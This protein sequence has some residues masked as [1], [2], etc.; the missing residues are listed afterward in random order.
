MTRNNNIDKYKTDTRRSILERM[1][2]LFKQRE[3]VILL[4]KAEKQSSEMQKRWLEVEERDE[5]MDEL[6][7]IGDGTNLTYETELMLKYL[8]KREVKS[9]KDVAII[10]DFKRTLDSCIKSEF[11]DQSENENY[12]K[13]D[14]YKDDYYDMLNR[15]S[16]RMLQV[17]CDKGAEM[18][19][20]RYFWFKYIASEL[21]VLANIFLTIVTA[22]LTSG[23]IWFFL[24]KVAGVEIE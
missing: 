10:T 11:I 24:L 20:W 16:P 23:A 22:L 4:D 17:S 15:T 1:A 21:P 19:D 9:T 18:L 2:N 5:S 7:I 13:K 12:L 8:N 3:L 14:H 6:H